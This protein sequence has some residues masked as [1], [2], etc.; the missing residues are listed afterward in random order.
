MTDGPP[1][2]AATRFSGRV[3]DYVRTRPGYPDALLAA[4]TA[5]VPLTPRAIVADIGSG[6]GISTELFLRCGATVY[7]VEPNPDMRHAAETRF[8]GVPAF[9]SVV[10]SAEATSL[11]AGSVR[12]I[13]A[14]Q[15]F[16]WFDRGAARREFTRI[17][18]PDGWVALFWNSRRLGDTPFLRA[19]EALLQEYGTD[20]REVNHQK[21]DASAVAAFFGAAV[22]SHVF[23]NAQML[24]HAGL[25]GRLLSSSYV[26]GREDSRHPAMLRALR[27]IFDAHQDEGRVE[28]RYD[29]ELHLGHL[30]P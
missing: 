14:G 28:I 9:H 10:G 17:L 30:I 27:R 21:I 8:S 23:P 20:Y 26:P 6:T 22:Q 12:L 18:E 16:H 25:E 19:Y 2:D 29:T 13:A 7:A 4:I 5:A 1:R 24:D 11:Q 15:A 3:T